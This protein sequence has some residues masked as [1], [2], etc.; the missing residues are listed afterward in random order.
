VTH[1]T[2]LSLLCSGVVLCAQSR[3]S[4]APSLQTGTVLCSGRYHVQEEINSELVDMK[5]S[6]VT[7]LKLL[8]CL[9][10]E[11]PPLFITVWTA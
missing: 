7:K 10:G 4:D 3:M 2:V 11:V 5:L 8:D 6:L 1:S 9:Q